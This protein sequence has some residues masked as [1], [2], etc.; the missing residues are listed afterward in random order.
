MRQFVVSWQASFSETEE[1]G[2]VTGTYKGIRFPDHD[3]L[4]RDLP[5]EF[6]WPRK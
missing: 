3:L 5:R 2:E 6:D 1:K 4:R